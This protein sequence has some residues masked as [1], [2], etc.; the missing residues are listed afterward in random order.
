MFSKVFSVLHALNQGLLLPVSHD[1]HHLP[2]QAGP[3]KPTQAFSRQRPALFL[4]GTS[5]LLAPGRDIEFGHRVS[6]AEMAHWAALQKR[7]PSLD[8]P[9]PAGSWPALPAADGKGPH[10]AGWDIRKVPYLLS[11]ST[12][13]R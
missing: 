5:I 7:L 13:Q 3:L 12:G 6:L 1:A 10:M 4:L 9:L 2:P 11:Y 8:S